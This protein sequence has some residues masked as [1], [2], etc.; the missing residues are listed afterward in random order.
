MRKVLVGIVV[1][2][3]VSS[4]WH[5]VSFAQGEDEFQ[6]FLREHQKEFLSYKKKIEEEFKEYVRINQEEFEKFKKEIL[7]YWE[8]AKVTTKKEWVEYS[9]DYK[10]RKVVDFEKGIVEVSVIGEKDE[11]AIKELKKEVEDL[12]L[13]DKSKAFE[14]DILAKRIEKR[15][16]E[17]VSELKTSSVEKERIL[18][19]IFFKGTPSRKEVKK[20]VEEL[21]KK[22]KKEVKPSKKV[23]GKKVY[24]VRFRLP[25]NALRKKAEQYKPLVVRFSSERK[26]PVELVFA[27][28]HTESSFNPLARSPVPAYGL[29]QIVPQTAGKDAS[30]LIFG[31]PKL[32]APSYLYNGENNIKVGTAYFY[33]LYYRYF[34]G[35]KDPRTRL[36]C[37]IAAYNTGIGNVARA[38]TGTTSLKKAVKKANSLSSEEVYEILM[39]NVP[40]E[41]KN[42]LKRVLSRMRLYAGI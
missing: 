14:R 13:E 17:K 11:D 15:L 36:Y 26:L 35:I 7:K 10:K 20:K 23:K 31:R 16:K 34:K 32:L 25:K 2:V 27:I 29:M 5:G 8:E 38:L 42:Y 39:R 41:T 22:A 9:K 3:L 1:L 4:L 37:S 28:I 21:F 30:K 18:T 24:T 33:L 40:D 19:P 12:L 6:K